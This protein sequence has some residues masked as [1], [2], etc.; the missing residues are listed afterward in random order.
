MDRV[1]YNTTPSHTLV[2]R[3]RNHDLIWTKSQ[4]AANCEA[5]QAPMTVSMATQLAIRLPLAT[6]LYGFYVVKQMIENRVGI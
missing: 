4:E 6:S 1:H 5:L 3:E 2:V